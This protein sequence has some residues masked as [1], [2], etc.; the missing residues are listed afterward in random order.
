[1][2]PSNM[3]VCLFCP[4]LHIWLSFNT[5][6]FIGRPPS[7]YTVDV[8]L[9]FGAVAMTL[10]ATIQNRARAHTATHTLFHNL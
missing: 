5:T 10:H 9:M 8:G 2:I 6:C 1:M 7:M 3:C 4:R